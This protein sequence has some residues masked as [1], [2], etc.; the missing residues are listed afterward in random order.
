MN[1]ELFQGKDGW[2]WHLKAGN[3]EIL[4]TSEAYDSKSNAER[5]ANLVQTALGPPHDD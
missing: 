3:G 4:A 2:R 5:T 1:V